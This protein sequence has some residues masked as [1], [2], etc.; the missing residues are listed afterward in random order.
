MSE[1]TASRRNPPAEALA[2][3][4]RDSRRAYEREWHIWTYAEM[5]DWTVK[6]GVSRTVAEACLNFQQQE[7]AACHHID[8][9]NLG[10]FAEWIETYGLQRWKDGEMAER[11]RYS[12]QGE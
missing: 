3:A 6:W 2:Q 7:E 9:V 4:G 10:E 11:E 1:H 8:M 12:Q 5:D